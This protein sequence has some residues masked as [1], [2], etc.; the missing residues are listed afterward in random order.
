[1]R[2]QELVEF[3]QRDISFCEG[4][5]QLNSVKSDDVQFAFY[6]GK[7]QGLQTALGL[8]VSDYQS[9]ISPSEN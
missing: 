9:S 2:I 6:Q 3:L 4:C 5:L 8:L 7:K 1:M